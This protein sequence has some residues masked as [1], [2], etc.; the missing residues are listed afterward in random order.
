VTPV[1][2]QG[3]CGSCWA[4]STTG[5]L[6]SAYA[7][8]NGLNVTEWEGFSEQELVSETRTTRTACVVDLLCPPRDDMRIVPNLYVTDV[9]LLVLVQVSC[10]HNGDEGCNGGFMDSA[11]QWIMDNGGICSETAYP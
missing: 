9:F 6:E 3:S 1:K 10:D 8:A 4:F 11:F 5:S 2:N 7:I